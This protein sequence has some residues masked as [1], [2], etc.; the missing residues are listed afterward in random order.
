MLRKLLKYEIKDTARVI[1]FFYLIAMFFAVMA[2]VAKQL[3]LGWLTGTSSFILILVGIAVVIITFV[4]VVMRFYKNL[5]SNEGYLMFTLP[6]KP[7]LLLASKTIVAFT[8][9]VISFVVAIV[10]ICVSL[11]GFGVNGTMLAEIMSEFEK[12]GLEKVIYFLI[13]MILLSI[14]Y[15]LAQIFFSI[16]VANRPAFYG[17]GAASAFLVFLATYVILQIVQSVLTIFVP[18]SIELNLVGNVSASLS[19][20]NMLGS[21][22]ENING[23]T[24][25]NIT[26]GLS[27]YVFVVIMICV[28]FYLIGR[29]M[30][31][32]VS[33]R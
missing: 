11:Y 23:L 25:T 22:L 7:Q 5:Y 10:A 20:K 15:L 6:V 30:N 8:W 21:L 4:V 18:F 29:M 28:L 17:M 12:Y 31:R 24:P 33:L 27:G 19:T 9:I 14:L 2:L 16:T 26:I 3:N 1:P 13:P 32:K